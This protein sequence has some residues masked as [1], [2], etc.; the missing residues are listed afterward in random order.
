MFVT[1]GASGIGL[2][3]A[4]LLLEKNA[5]VHIIDLVEPDEEDWQDWPRFH[6]H[7]A[8]VRNW[9]QLSDVFTE[10]DLVDY[11]FVNAGL[12]MLDDDLLVDHLDETGRLREPKFLEVDTNIRGVFNTSR[13]DILPLL[14]NVR[15]Q[16]PQRKTRS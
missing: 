2:A 1:G 16:V 6:V 12:G 8:D 7:K 14:L 10:I 13:F 9:I 11:V 5:T 4:K 3:A 15:R